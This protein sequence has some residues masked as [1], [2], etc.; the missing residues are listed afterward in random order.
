MSDTSY[1]SYNLDHLGLISA[2]VDELGL[3]SLIDTLIPQDHKQRHVS[4]GT[5]VK[6]M[7][8]NGLG[9]ANRTLYLM[10]HFFKDKP[11]ERLL[12]EGIKAEH[13]NDDTLGRAMDSVCDY[14]TSNFYAQLAAQSVNRLGL[15]CEIG[16]L[17][18][19]TFHVDGDYNSRENAEDLAEG[20][21]HITKGYSRDHRPDLNQVV[22]QLICEN[23]AGIPLWMK[24]LSG[25]SNDSS[26]FRETISTHLS[27][28]KEI[29]GMKMMVADSA[30]YAKKTL[31]EL[32]EFGWMSRVPETIGGV[33]ELCQSMAQEW[34]STSPFKVFL[35]D[36]GHF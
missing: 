21:I 24:A 19:S 36:N 18:S 28:I 9:F 32:G 1:N 8:L 10:P 5:C 20:V 15:S 4:V 17:D 12:G 29:F 6:A 23:Q 27:Q 13:L 3:V 16:H 34:S 25:N 14:G 22:L 33:S 30:L 35:A 31:K 7:I 26:D 2:M 11:I